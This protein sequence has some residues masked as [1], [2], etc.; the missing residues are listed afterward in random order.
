MEAIGRER[1]SS[2][3]RMYSVDREKESAPAL[4]P[5]RTSPA[6]RDGC[7]PSPGP[8]IGQALRAAAPYV[9]A[10]R[11][12]TFVVALLGLGGRELAPDALRRLVGDLALV[13]TLGAR[14]VVTFG[15]VPA[16]ALPA[17]VDGDGIEALAARTG[18]HRAELEALLTMGLASR[19]P[20]AGPLRVLSGNHVTARPLGIRDGIDYGYAGE[21]RRIDVEGIEAGLR[22]GAL[23]LVTP[24]AYSPSGAALALEPLELALELGAA[25]QASKLLL[26]G[27]S[28]LAPHGIPRELSLEAARR[29]LASE[30]E[31]ERGERP[32]RGEGLPPGSRALQVALRACERGVTRVHLLDGSLDGALLTELYSRDGIG[33]MVASDV[34]DE[35]R[36]A[37]PEDIPGI[38]DLIRPLEAA[39]ILVHRPRERLEDEI[40][41]FW[42]MERDGLVLACAALHPLDREGAWELAC[43]AVHPE[44]RSTERGDEL[45]RHMERV[46]R[47][48]GARELFV[49]TTRAEDWF[50]ERGF[51]P[52]RPETL[53]PGRRARYRPERRSRVLRKPI[54][55]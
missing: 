42:V 32:G 26:L 10:Y 6:E 2:G 34:Y 15:A 50:R 19:L 4:A 22:G 43:V 41:C 30:S 7:A 37:R 36:P 12:R 47:A 13:H 3:R 51:R 46:A 48:R 11:E 16:R 54:G 23:M 17:P 33:V 1:A 39:D 52:C 25:L 9:A 20:R 35:T 45:L 55:G 49:L 31:G 29:R 24:L 5:G 21:V 40:E 28:T 18:R 53:P 14:L 44:Y 38:L 27:D 8:G